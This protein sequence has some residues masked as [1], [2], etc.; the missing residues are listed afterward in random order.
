MQKRTK[1]ILASTTAVLFLAGAVGVS[2]AKEGFQKGF[3]GGS[4]F[5]QHARFGGHGKSMGGGHSGM[6]DKI[7]EKFDVDKNGTISKTEIDGVRKNELAKADANKDGK[8]SLNEF[9]S[10]WTGLMRERMVDHFQRLDND[11]DA[12]V[13]EEEIAK[14][15]D[16][17]LSF[18][19]RNNDGS[20]TKD[21][22]QRKHRGWGGKYRGR[23]HDDHDDDDD[24]KK[25]K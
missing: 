14:P 8:L 13:T 9:Q 21:E 17:M 5:M 24:D 12:E 23:H 1:I 22:L 2:K 18:M 10:L 19:D 3:H 16:R 15:M 7:F 20:I 4:G 11:G 25:S 6:A